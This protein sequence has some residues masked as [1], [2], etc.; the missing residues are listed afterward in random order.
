[1]YG[2]NADKLF[3]VVVQ[4]I[5]DSK[6]QRGSYVIKRYGNVGAKEERINL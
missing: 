5:R 1:M 3:D 6:P 4:A 2:A